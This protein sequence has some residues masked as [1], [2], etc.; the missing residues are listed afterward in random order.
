MADKELVTTGDQTLT[1]TLIEAVKTAP[2]AVRAVRTPLG[3]FSLIGTIIQAIF[4]AIVLGFKT[5]PTLQLVI[6]I[7]MLTALLGSL[8]TVAL[9]AWFRPHA[10]RGDDPMPMPGFKTGLQVGTQVVVLRP[11]NR[12][13][14]AAIDQIMVWKKSMNRFVGRIAEIREIDEKAKVA[15]LDIDYG[16]N[17]WSFSWLY[18]R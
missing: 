5:D 8:L 2:G 15:R 16:S 17:E 3:Y 7:G 12:N 6:V 14:P 18:W 13:P 4:L 9:M 10:L 1:T 11:V